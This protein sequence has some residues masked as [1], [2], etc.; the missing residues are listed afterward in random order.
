VFGTDL[1]DFM[2]RLSMMDARLAKKSP[3]ARH[4][5]QLMHSFGINLDVVGED[6]YLRSP[7]RVLQEMQKFNALKPQDRNAALQT[8]FGMQGGQ[9]AQLMVQTDPAKLA[10]MLA[11]GDNQ[12]DLNMR[13]AMTTSTLQN[14][15]EALKG[16]LENLLAQIGTQAGN[17]LKGPLDSA[18][19]LFGGPVQGFFE[20]HP[21]AGTAGLLGAG[22]LG[23]W[24]VGR[25][26]SKAIAGLLG[27]SAAAA[28]AEGAAATAASGLGLAR[29][30][31]AG[32]GLFAAIQGYRVLDAASDLYNIGNREGVQLNPNAAARMTLLPPG[33]D[34]MSLTRPGGVGAGQPSAFGNALQIGEGR[35]AIDV[36]VHDDR[37]T[38]TTAVNKP[39]SLVRI[40]N[41]NTNPAGYG[42]P[43]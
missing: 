19:S 12:G 4:V 39:M 35:L 33:T 7:T 25:L 31:V 14:R 30:G 5:R 24:L 1:K 40:D 3:E 8:I 22:G 26:G 37:I 28:G 36:T 20:D 41:G 27:R 43:R 34:F 15:F 17:G 38:A 9:M 16:T 21:A 10:G 29:F 6:G 23:A 2:L 42:M 11:T 13:L 32:A 18:N